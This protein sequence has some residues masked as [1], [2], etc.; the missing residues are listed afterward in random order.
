MSE[1]I[2]EESRR[3]ETGGLRTLGGNFKNLLRNLTASVVRHGTPTT[4]RARS[5]T[6]VQNFFL[7][8]H[9]ARVHRWS[10]R[11][12]FTLGLGLVSFFS[13]TILAV[14]GVLL[15]LYYKPTTALAYA[16]MKE[17]HFMV[18][19]GRL[20]RNVHRW[21]AHLMVAAVILHMVRVFFTASYKRSRQFNW[22]VGILL[23]VLTM[24]LS[25]TG[26]LLPWDQLA[27]W[28]MMIGTNIATSV[29][30]VTDA[31]Q[32]TEHFDPG[33]YMQAALMGSRNLGDESLIRF[34]MLHCMFLP[35][36]TAVFIGVHFWRIRKDGG[37]SRPE[38]ADALLAPRPRT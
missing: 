3:A 18:P 35:L 28:A 17:I 22:T 1:R 6:V 4:D 9:S 25:Y 13:F 19:A 16:S 34:N 27:Y 15:M 2:S 11:P 21:A 8:L 37:M 31:L 23:W 36:L 12:S 29:R 14:T 10:L 38:N 30:E 7:H 32:I 24:A 33:A 5:E 20:I 26:Y